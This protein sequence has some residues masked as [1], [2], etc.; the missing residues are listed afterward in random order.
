MER[1]DK[2]SEVSLFRHHRALNAEV[3]E[4]DEESSEK[5]PLSRPQVFPNFMIPLNIRVIMVMFPTP[6]KK[7]FHMLLR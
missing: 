4:R 1:D 7:N 2:F 6:S 5:V 3:I